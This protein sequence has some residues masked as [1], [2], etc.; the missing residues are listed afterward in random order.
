MSTAD[1]PKQFIALA[2]P[3]HTL[4]Q[5]AVLRGAALDQAGPVTIVASDRHAGVIAEQLDQI[6]CHA[7][8]IILEP[9]GRNTAPAI[10][11]AALA[12]PSSETLLLVMPSDQVIADADAFG[13]AVARARGL[14]P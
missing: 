5:Q 2:H 6:G 1:R 9:V 7:G 13:A 4:L 14:S 11:A 10:A 3:T 12:A 8:A